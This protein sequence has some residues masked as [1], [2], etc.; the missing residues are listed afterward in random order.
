VRL[1]VLRFNEH[2]KLSRSAKVELRKALPNCRVVVTSTQR[3]EVVGDPFEI[4][5]FNKSMY[6]IVGGGEITLHESLQSG[7]QVPL[8]KRGQ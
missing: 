4:A 3:P 2:N 7:K 6:A 5:E 8:S 1:K